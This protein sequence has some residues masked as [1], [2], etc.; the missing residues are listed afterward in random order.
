MAFE[1]TSPFLNSFGASKVAPASEM[2]PVQTLPAPCAEHV[3]VLPD[4]LVETSEP[5]NLEADAQLAQDWLAPAEHPVAV[6]EFIPMEST[7]QPDAEAHGELAFGGSEVATAGPEEPRL[8]MPVEQSN[9]HGREVFEGGMPQPVHA[10]GGPGHGEE[11]E[12]P[13]QEEAGFLPDLAANGREPHEV[14]EEAPPLQF[15]A[16]RV[17]QHSEPSEVVQ[18]RADYE[19]RLMGA[20]QQ[21][22][23]L[24]ARIEELESEAAAAKD[25]ELQLSEK[26]GCMT[27]QLTEAQAA[28]QQAEAASA[29]LQ[30]EADQ[31]RQEASAASERARAQ[32]A[33]A[34]DAAF[35]QVREEMEREL[36]HLL[37]QKDEQ[38]RAIESKF[39]TSERSRQNATR[40]LEAL[41]HEA[42]AL[43]QELER[44]HSDSA[45]RTSDHERSVEQLTADYQQQIA[46]LEE[47]RDIEERQKHELALNLRSVEERSRSELAQL[48]AQ[49]TQ[50]ELQS[51]ALQVQ[52][53]PLLCSRRV[54]G[55]ISGGSLCQVGGMR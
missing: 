49:K 11:P 21:I 35:G 38:L 16:Q 48:E 24:Q 7:R 13:A 28:R 30:R 15:E 52:P 36:E 6:E 53:T 31:L 25:V 51:G 5:Q 37:K 12:E 2:Q 18:V 14:P 19:A 27:M 26:M 46:E 33:E 20:V 55:F 45:G 34:S 43:K 17:E 1:A 22:A 10:N 3:E 40:D 39:A 50:L 41:T 47:R 44:L 29:Q 23:H 4:D 32:A 9:G 42:D 8:E 54:S